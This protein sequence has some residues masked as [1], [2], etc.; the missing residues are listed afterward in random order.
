MTVDAAS[1]KRSGLSVVWDVIVAPQSAFESLR[2]RPQWLWA[3]LVVCVL[4]MIGAVLQAPAGQ[5]IAIAT[6]QHQAA[7]DPNMASMTPAQL[8]N[9]THIAA[10]IQ[11]WVWLFYPVIAIVAIL[12]ATVVLLLGNA[13]AH[14]TANFVRLFALAANVAV[15]NFGLGYLIIG[16]LG[17]MRGPAEFNTQID[18]L[19]LMPSLAWLA[20]GAA[21]K[22]LALLNGVNP[23]QIWSF[24]LLALGLRTIADMKP[25]PAYIVAALV[26]F[27][28]AAIG[29]LFI[30]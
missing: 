2:T 14:G 28:A 25:V 5:H 26:S 6:I 18:L 27:G 30:K 3:Y 20:P 23:L 4:G 17:A 11:K 7:H 16:A 13:I 8:Q 22:V 15:I 29:V 19:T 10:E 9:M 21:P 24:I 1:Q 12:F